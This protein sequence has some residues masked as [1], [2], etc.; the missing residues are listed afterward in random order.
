MA[1]TDVYAVHSGYAAYRGRLVRHGVDLYELRASG[2][3]RTTPSFVGTRASLHT[4]AFVLDGRR[5]FV[6]SFNVDPRSKNLNTEMGVL[7]D[8]PVMGAQLREEYLRLSG[9]ELSYHVYQDQTGRLRW[10]DR[11]QPTPLVLDTEPE[12]GLWQRMLVRV[13]GW[14]PIESQL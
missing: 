4:K 14:L 6:G 8:D 2:G 9:A 10:L 13:S 3:E 11:A 7:F 1:A 12:A 5:G